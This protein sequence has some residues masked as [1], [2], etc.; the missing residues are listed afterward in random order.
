MY[1]RKAIKD[2][3]QKYKNAEDFYFLSLLTLVTGLGTSN[4]LMSWGQFGLIIAWL[5]LGKYSQQWKNFIYQKH[6]LAFSSIYVLFLFGLIHSENLKY[7]FHDLRIKLPILI[8]PFLFAGLPILSLKRTKIIFHLFLGVLLLS[9]VIG[10]FMYLK[11]LP[12]EINNVRK[13][14]PFISSIRF[15]TLLVFGIF[16]CIWLILPD[17]K[18]YRLTL[19]LLYIVPIL[20]FI[21]FLFLLQSVTGLIILIVISWV[22]LLI[23]VWKIKK[24]ALKIFPIIFLL[25]I[26][27]LTIFYIKNEVKKFYAFKSVST[28]NLEKSTPDGSIYKHDTLSWQ[29]ENGNYVWLYVCNWELKREWNKRSKIDFDGKTTNG[30]PLR[31]TLIR[32]LTSKGVKKNAF[33]IQSLSEKEIKAIENGVTNIRFLNSFGFNDRIYEL[34]WEYHYYIHSKDPNGKSL[35]MR[36]EFWKFGWK[37]VMRSPFW[38]HGTGD[39]RSALNKELIESKSKLKPVYWMN[40]HQQY[41]SVALAIGIPGLIIFVMLVLYAFYK[42]LKLNFLQIVFSLICLIAMLDDDPLETQ[43]GV[44]QFVFWFCFL[45]STFKENNKHEK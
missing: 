17:K 6:L 4:I 28:S 7:A 33:A 26:P 25:I 21:I 34:I 36:L 1:K 10:F 42:N 3:I 30:W 38:G 2:L 37:A 43:A 27:F 31:T 18:E 16:L 9:C 14:A 45:F 22:M 11:I 44:T 29:V 35:A 40:P 13:Y 41:L 23:S 32:Y 15:S 20:V 39:V 19:P 5:W 8:L 24:T 12:I